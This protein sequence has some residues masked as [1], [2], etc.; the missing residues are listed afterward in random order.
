VPS[1]SAKLAV[2]NFDAQGLAGTL[3]GVVRQAALS[4]AGNAVGAIHSACACCALHRMES[5]MP[6]MRCTEPAWPVYACSLLG[7]SAG[8]RA[9]LLLDTNVTLDA[10]QT[11]E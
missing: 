2:A 8:V 3:E 4:S 9:Q 6:H 10:L 1:A 11:R 7:A 5:T